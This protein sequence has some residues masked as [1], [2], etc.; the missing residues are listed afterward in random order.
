MVVPG[1]RGIVRPRVVAVPQAHDLDSLHRGQICYGLP[2]LCHLTAWMVQLGVLVKELVKVCHAARAQAH[3][4]LVQGREV[5]GTTQVGHMAHE[6]VASGVGSGSRWAAKALQ[7]MKVHG[8]VSEVEAGAG[9]AA[10]PYILQLRASP[11][12]R[13]QACLRQ[14]GLHLQHALRLAGGAPCLKAAQQPRNPGRP[15][16]VPVL[17]VQL[18]QQSL[19][20]VEDALLGV[21]DLAI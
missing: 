18:R 13:Q 9:E 17:K 11:H 7:G 8:D 5:D 12:R 19:A 10:P 3:Q 2:G 6:V 15:W 1:R 20:A 4:G 14:H 21:E 16:L